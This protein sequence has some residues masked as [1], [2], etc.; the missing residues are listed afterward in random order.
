MRELQELEPQLEDKR[1]KQG[2]FLAAAQSHAVSP[3]QASRASK[4]NLK[5][6]V[7]K[8]TLQQLTSLAMRSLRKKN[9]EQFH[10]RDPLYAAGHAAIV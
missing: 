7:S 4:R 1:E 6:S 9:L 8:V 5:L 2:K 3:P 10:A